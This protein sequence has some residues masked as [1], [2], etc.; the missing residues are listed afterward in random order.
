[1]D[2]AAFVTCGDKNGTNG[3]HFPVCSEDVAFAHHFMATRLPLILPPYKSA[4]DIGY[5]SKNTI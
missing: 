5:I 4:G 3:S 1:M 2:L